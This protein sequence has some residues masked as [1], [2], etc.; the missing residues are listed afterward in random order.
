LSWQGIKRSSFLRVFKEPVNVEVG[1]LG[2]EDSIKL[3]AAHVPTRLKQQYPFFQIPERFLEIFQTH[4]SEE[5]QDIIWGSLGAG[6][7]TRNCSVVAGNKVE[8]ASTLQSRAGN[9]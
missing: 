9:N 6:N 3:F 8:V 7:L 1:P 4:L 2:F 5:D